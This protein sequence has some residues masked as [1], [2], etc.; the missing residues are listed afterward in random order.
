MAAMSEG[1]WIGQRIAKLAEIKGLNQ[2]EL[3]DAVGISQ[4]YVSKIMSGDR[5]V[6]KW[7]TLERF[8]EVL[9]VPVIDL[10]GLPM[11]V[12][13][14]H[15]LLTRTTV[16]GIRQALYYPDDP[17][18][19]RPVALLEQLTRRMAVARMECDY[20]A[21]GVGLPGLLTESRARYQATPT[22]PS[23]RVLAQAAVVASLTLKPLGWVDLAHRLG[24][25]G[26]TVAREVEDRAAIAA[27]EYAVAQC[28]RAAGATRHSLTIATDAAEA[29]LP[30]GA[31]TRAW[32]GLLHLHAGYC[33][34][35]LNDWGLAQD[36]FVEAEALAARMGNSDPWSM[37]F[38]PANVAT[39]RVGAALE[40]GRPQDAPVLA[41][42]VD[43]SA[44]KTKQRL[45]R[46]HMD[47]GRG[48][49]LA[50]QPDRAVAEFLRAHEVAP[51]EL[52]T[53][54]S[55]L[56]IVGQMHRDAQGGGSEAL[57]RLVEITG[58]AGDAA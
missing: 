13:T 28:V 31:A 57:R 32:R 44:L 21:L 18:R 7:S 33:A 47:T 25:L 6:T 19:P 52:R 58:V 8:A 46:L 2:Q 3:G 17:V 37:E 35:G 29:T 30:D 24:E 4:G 39:W 5:P 16:E 45:S 15:D 55:V 49:Y 53:R 20:A 34:A 41:R 11:A 12:R 14:P 51:A 43:R 42:R 48:W 50:E 40:N 1:V 22:R 27:A 38:T 54:P 36:H 23:G 56:E 10:I 26:S 9:G